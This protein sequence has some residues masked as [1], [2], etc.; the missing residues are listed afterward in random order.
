MNQVLRDEIINIAADI[1][2]GERV[3]RPPFVRCIL[4]MGD[5][6]A[7]MLADPVPLGA[8]FGPPSPT[9]LKDVTAA[10]MQAQFAE[11]QPL[12]HDLHAFLQE[13]VPPADPRSATAP[14]QQ[15]VDELRREAG[16]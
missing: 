11:R 10:D 13:P 14:T 6:A 8:R 3:T 7:H 2:G 1:R 5:R 9:S 4:D 12:W 16:L 15:E